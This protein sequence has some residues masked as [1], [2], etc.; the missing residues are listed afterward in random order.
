MWNYRQDN[1]QPK[2]NYGIGATTLNKVCAAL[3]RS[4]KNIAEY[5]EEL[6]PFS[7]FLGL[8]FS[9]ILV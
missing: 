3:H 1:R 5:A 2:E 4:L 6:F 8:T 7:Q 9:D